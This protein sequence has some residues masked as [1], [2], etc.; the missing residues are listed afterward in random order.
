MLQF[1][2]TGRKLAD[3]QHV[4]QHVGILLAREFSR[5]VRRHGGADSLEQVADGETVPVGRKL[6]SSERRRG[7]SAAEGASV[8]RR[9]VAGVE[10]GS[11]LGLFGCVDTVPHGASGLGGEQ[12]GSKNQNE[13]CLGMSADA[14][15]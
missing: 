15:N 7:L 12:P 14:A 11:T 13:P 10:R 9:A 6:A 1:G 3:A 2:F 5:T 8:A 4:R